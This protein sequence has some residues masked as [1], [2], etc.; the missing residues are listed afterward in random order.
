MSG[1]YIHIPFCKQACSY[2]DFHFSTKMTSK[3]TMVLTLCKE[4]MLRKDAFLNKRIE[5]VYF[6]GGTPSVLSAVEITALLE[7]VNTHYV[8]SHRAEITLEANPDD[9][10]EDYVKALSKTGVNRLS[11]GVQ[12]FNEHAL[13]FMNRAHTTAQ[14]LEALG[15]VNKYFSNYSL[16][17]IYGLPALTASDSKAKALWEQDVETALSFNPPHISAYAL[18]VEPKTALEHQ[19]KTGKLAALDED[20]AASQYLYLKKKLKKV[21]YEHYEF[22]NF[23][24]PSFHSVNNTAYWEGK[25][26]LGIGPS[27]HS[28]DGECRSWNVANNPKYLTAI[29]SEKLPSI[30]E[31]LDLA[32]RY[33]EF[34]MMGLRTAK[35]V[36]LHK[37]EALFGPYFLA[38]A[39]REAA[40]KINEGVLVLGADMV[41]K[42][43]TKAQFLTD[44]LAAHLFYI[45]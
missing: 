43:P 7:A 19:I 18:T 29:D 6:G 40:V 15:W 8:L 39:K 2:C 16:D 45:D 3:A 30:K 1:I 35:G 24:K 32:S 31:V 10:T 5:S 23:S 38:Y 44:G 20:M 33:N 13:K 36:S 22:S 37:I 28:Y 26:Y 9:L 21:G 25:S 42:V 17:L 27:A 12:S 34:I 14:A 4:L 11:I 41:L